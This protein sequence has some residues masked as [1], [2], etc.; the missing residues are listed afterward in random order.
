MYERNKSNHHLYDGIRSVILNKEHI[1]SEFK[2]YV[3]DYNVNDPKIMLKIAH[4][5]R[6]AE[7]CNR[8][9]ES[10]NLNDEDKA[11]A[12]TIGMLHD[13]A[14]F[15]QVRIYGS[16]N[17]AE[18]VDHAEFGVELLFKDNLIER[19]EIEEEWY[20]IINTA[21]KYHNKF[22]I[23]EGLSDR[24]ILFCKIIRDADKI[25]ILRVN[26]ET[27]VEEIYNTTRDILVRDRISDNVYN[28]FFE[29]SAVNHGI[30]ETVMDRVVGHI[31]LCFELEFEISRSIVL[32][33]GYL[34]KLLAF[35]SENE[36][37]VDRLEKIGTYILDFLQNNK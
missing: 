37:T 29:N 20:P 35:E 26:I 21:I 34:Q 31:S 7:L 17:D 10:I 36:E 2:N 30:K 4:T 8:V 9:A 22:R 5:Y 11:L 25:D 24:E 6:V 1:K 27:P 16:F 23:P 13:I 28:A 18:T 15:E 32:E 14:R 19:F 3:S 33:Q 12:W